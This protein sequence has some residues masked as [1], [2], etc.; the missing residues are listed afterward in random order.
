MR[1]NKEKNDEKERFR[2]MRISLEK[3]SKVLLERFP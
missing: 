1:E 2:K 3:E